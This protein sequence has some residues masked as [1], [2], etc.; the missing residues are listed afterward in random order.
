MSKVTRGEF[1]GVGGWLAAGFGTSAFGL[2]GSGFLEEKKALAVK[3]PAADLILVNGKVQ[4]V[5]D[6]LPKAEAFA[7]K[8]GRFVAV[9]S[10]SDIR[11]LASADTQVIDAGGMFVTPGF[12][13]CHC[14]PSG[15][16]DLY[17][18]NCDVTTI[19]EVLD[20]LRKRAATTKPGYWVNGFKYDD[21]NI[22]DEKTGKYR[23][24]TRE[25]LDSA[26]SHLPVK[27]THRG[28]HISWYNSKAFEMAGVTKNTPDPFGG[29]FE[30]DANGELTGLVQER[31][32]EAFSKVGK[33][34]PITRAVRQE[35]VEYLSREMAKS[36]LTS[37]HQTGYFVGTGA[38]G[39]LALQDAYRA[40][41]LSFR[42]YNFPRGADLMKAMYDAGIYTGFGDEYVKVGG[43]KYGCDGSCSGRSMAMYTPYIG[44]PNDY[45]VLTMSQ[46][47]IHAA[48][49]ESHRHNFQIGIHANGDKAI[50]MV[51]NAYERVQKLWPRADARHRI[52]HCTL[53]NP[54]ILGRIKAGGIIPTP[55]WTYCYYHG[56]KFG[57]YGE[58]RLK[59]MFAHRSF[60]DYGIPVAGASD[61]VPG[62]FEP[63][64]AIQSMVTRK[65][66]QGRLWGVNQ[67]ITIDEAIR[68]GT[69]NGAHAS[70]EEKQKG[71]IT[72][73]KYADF[74]MFEKD[75]HTVDPDQIKNVK[76]VRTV[77]GGRTT[78]EA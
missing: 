40:G 60:L 29:R 63:L 35:G 6:A 37:V 77:L 16:D 12:I 5:D 55:F 78:H 47:E 33:T 32:S 22:V 9:G 67:K 44:K 59:W 21:T 34:D 65:D 24:I 26:V 52:E 72:A 28:G 53:V 38:D 45:G 73:G 10:T 1:L 48:V 3:G 4:T 41:N 76:V 27:V 14:H 18:A 8:D 68:V 50:D 66:R 39:F 51:L 17:G 25:D 74:V 31:A 23:R 70:F 13:D 57:E 19:A 46:E 69:I 42:M 11:N 49:E 62:P 2:K 15:V 58:E 71:S 30:H 56:A 7:V 61:Y 20:V 54:T 64:M 36:G 75:V 43:V